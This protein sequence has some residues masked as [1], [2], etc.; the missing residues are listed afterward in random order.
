MYK[1]QITLT[2]HGYSTGDKIYYTGNS[3]L[4]DG[5]YFVIRDSL[6]TF[7]LAETIYETNPA[8]EKEI[9]ITSN[10]SERIRLLL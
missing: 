4:D 7:R 9:N 1:N 5:D 8:T 3:S 6:N 2:D 10:G